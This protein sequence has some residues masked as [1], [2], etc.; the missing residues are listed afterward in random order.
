M[1]WANGPASKRILQFHF[2]YVLEFLTID[3]LNLT[4]CYNWLKVKSD[5]LDELFYVQH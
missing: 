5:W 2:S 4:G 1:S 3:L